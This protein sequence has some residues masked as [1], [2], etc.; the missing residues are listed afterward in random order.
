M[1]AFFEHPFV[2]LILAGA[3]VFLFGHQG[4][5]LAI[6]L[7]CIFVITP[8]TKWLQEFGSFARVAVAILAIIFGYLLQGY[9]KWAII[10]AT[11]GLLYLIVT[12]VNKLLGGKLF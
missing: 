1:K 9:S 12:A 4:L 6:A 8:F 3:V 7:C 10:A 11:I 5:G 2:V